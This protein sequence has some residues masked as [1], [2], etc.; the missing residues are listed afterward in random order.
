APFLAEPS[1]APP[2]ARPAPPAQPRS[3][4]PELW[5]EG[6]RPRA[7]A[8]NETFRDFLASP[9]L[10]PQATSAPPRPASIGHYR[11]LQALG[12]GGMGTVYEAEQDNPRRS[13]ALKVIRGDRTT[14]EVVQR[15]RREAH[16][17]GRLQ[18]P[19]IAQVYEARV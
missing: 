3:D 2:R 14:P 11:L 17:L 19:G 7:H 5:A 16:I 10:R 1:P 15:F 18:H 6:E 13:V 8:D 4:G 9:L 12:A